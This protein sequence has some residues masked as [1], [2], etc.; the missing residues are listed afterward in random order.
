MKKEPRPQRNTTRKDTTLS[1]IHWL[2]LIA[3][4]AAVLVC[5]ALGAASV[6][7]WLLGG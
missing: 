5:F 4:A 3:A 2:D 6:G 1:V 7:R